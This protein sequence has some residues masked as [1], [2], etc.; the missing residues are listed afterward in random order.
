MTAF[1][2][3]E[4]R[5]FLEEELRECL[6]SL[7]LPTDEIKQIIGDAHEL[8]NSFFY[9]T[10]VDWMPDCMDCLRYHNETLIRLVNK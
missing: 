3:K 2:T 6:E 9:D 1:L 10:M 4:D 5:Q 8:S 7:D